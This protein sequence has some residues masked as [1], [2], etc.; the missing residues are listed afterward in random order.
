MSFDPTQPNQTSDTEPQSN[1]FEQTYHDELDDLNPR[2]GIGF[3][4]LPFAIIGVVALL[5]IIIFLV[6]PLRSEVRQQNKR[7]TTLEE[8]VI[9]IET[10][11][12][13]TGPS[14]IEIQKFSDQ[15]TRLQQLSAR[16]DRVETSLSA[17]LDNITKTMT[18]PA[19]PKPK[20]T[21]AQKKPAPTKPDVPK[22]DV[23][24]P[25]AASSDEVKYHLVQKGDTLYSIGRRNGIS[26]NILRSINNLG[27]NQT[28][29]PGQKLRVSQ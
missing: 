23:T 9:Q 25:A 10:R 22:S 7:L 18:A 27:P 2:K 21:V 3:S 1:K 15:E 16:M 5:V 6:I 13:Q 4:E 14:D 17:R 20:P 19:P 12:V 24:K 28:I 11:A 29:K 26:V 8:R